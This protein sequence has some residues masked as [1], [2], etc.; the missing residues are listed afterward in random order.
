MNSQEQLIAKLQQELE[1][2]KRSQVSVQNKPKTSKTPKIVD[3]VI[4]APVGY[5]GDKLAPI[6]G[7]DILERAKAYQKTAQR[8][9]DE[10]LELR[11]QADAKIKQAQDFLLKAQNLLKKD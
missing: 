8:L 2:L 4:Y 5:S 7:F 10:A 6:E 1:D 9:E 11:R 3:K